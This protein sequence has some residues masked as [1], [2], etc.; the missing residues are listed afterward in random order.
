MLIRSLLSLSLVALLVAGGHADAANP[1]PASGKSAPAETDAK[2]KDSDAAHPKL[3][4]Q[5]ISP[6]APTRS[7]ACGLAGERAQ[8]PFVSGENLLKQSWDDK[9]KVG[10][11][12]L[13][14]GD[15]VWVDL[16]SCNGY[17]VVAKLIVPR[18]PKSS[19]TKYWLTRIAQVAALLQGPILEDEATA[20]ERI[21][22]SGKWFNR[23]TSTGTSFDFPPAM[24][25]IQL[26]A[27]ITDYED[28]TVLVLSQ[29]AS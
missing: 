18:G 21:A 24:E 20:L 2:A 8:N 15:Y 3:E 4:P 27:T 29:S 22:R 28:M 12:L 6:K 26:G 13:S 14:T 25:H 9:E 11:A 7:D 5:I 17:G 1:P 23:K 16:K 19:D 10:R